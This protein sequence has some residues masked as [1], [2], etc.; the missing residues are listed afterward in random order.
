[1]K[2]N[3]YIFFSTVECETVFDRKMRQ[4]RGEEI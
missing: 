2:A 1:M 4:S 3:I